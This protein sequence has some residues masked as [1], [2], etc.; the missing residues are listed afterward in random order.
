MRGAGLVFAACCFRFGCADLRFGLG[1]GWGDRFFHQRGVASR[2]AAS[3]R[4]KGIAPG[5]FC[6]PMMKVGVALT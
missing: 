2:T 4:S 6:V 1:R 5:S 3:K